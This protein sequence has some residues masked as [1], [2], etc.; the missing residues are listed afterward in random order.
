LRVI[1]AYPSENTSNAFVDDGSSNAATLEALKRIVALD[2]RI[3]VVQNVLL[4]R[5]RASRPSLQT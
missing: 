3:F 4:A 1:D 5:G 2:E